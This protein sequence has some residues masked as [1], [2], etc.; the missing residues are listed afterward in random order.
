MLSQGRE[1]CINV[2]GVYRDERDRRV[3]RGCGNRRVVHRSWYWWLSS[4]QG[5]GSPSELSTLALAHTKRLVTKVSLT[6]DSFSKTSFSQGGF[7]KLDI[8]K[9]I[10]NYLSLEKILSVK[11]KRFFFKYVYKSSDENIMKH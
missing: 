5:R 10:S 1:V 9:A 8:I 6:P 7:R 2:G 4:S 11:M 3:H